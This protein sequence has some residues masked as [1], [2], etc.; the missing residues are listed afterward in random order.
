M[1]ATVLALLLQSPLAQAECVRYALAAQ[2]RFGFQAGE[3]M[4]E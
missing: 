1:L 3:L 4:H 2:D